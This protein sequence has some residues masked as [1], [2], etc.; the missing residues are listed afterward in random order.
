MAQTT[1]SFQP[2]NADGKPEGEKIQLNVDVPVGNS[3]A[4]FVK[5]YGEQVAFVAAV[6]AIKVM[7][8]D[9]GRKMLASGKTPADVENFLTSGWKP[10]ETL[11]RRKKSD[12]EK[13]EELWA[14]LPEDQKA[15]LRAKLKKS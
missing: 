13:F 4:E 8:G 1:I 3:L 15:A 10:P 14:K 9:A 11:G 2:K 12:A 5:L 6:K 7:A